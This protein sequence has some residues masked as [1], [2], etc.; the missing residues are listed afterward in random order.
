MNFEIYEE[1]AL[2]K[3]IPNTIFKKGDIGTIIGIEESG[4]KS[5]I[6]IEFFSLLGVSL[7]QFTIP[8]Q[9]VQ[10]ILPNSIPSMRVV[11]KK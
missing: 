7:G 10:N 4:T 1:V 2:K 11:K 3:N 9:Y 6:I 8:I 5:F